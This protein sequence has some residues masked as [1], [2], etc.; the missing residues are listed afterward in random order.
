MQ[1]TEK[2][3]IRLRLLE[4]FPDRPK[5]SIEELVDYVFNGT[6]VFDT[7]KVH[8]NDQP[9]DTEYPKYYTSAYDTPCDEKE[10]E[11]WELLYASPIY[12]NRYELERLSKEATEKINIP[13]RIKPSMETD[14]QY[15]IDTFAAYKYKENWY[16]IVRLE[17]D[18]L[19]LRDFS[20]LRL[21]LRPVSL[22]NR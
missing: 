6:F 21:T 3:E 2:Q 19:G 14:Y 15:P 13:I 16:E 22:F 20:E 11:T 4:S 10:D 1:L 5:E 17:Q 18:T 12:I 8:V 7:P 9:S